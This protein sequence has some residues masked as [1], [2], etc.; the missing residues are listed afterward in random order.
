[1]PVNVTLFG[2][3]VFADDQIMKSLR[4]ALIQYDWHACKRGK[5]RHRHTQG[6]CEDGDRSEGNASTSQEMPKSLASHQKLGEKPAPSQPQKQPTLP[7]PRSWN[8]SLQNCETIHF[9]LSHQFVV[10]CYSSLGKR[11]HSPFSLPYL[12]LLSPT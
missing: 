6:G 1:M 2:K 12:G 5:F 9:C 7:T 4:W 3:R 8:P 11:T 10:F